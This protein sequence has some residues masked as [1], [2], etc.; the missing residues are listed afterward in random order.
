MCPPSVLAAPI[1]IA[2]IASDPFPGA[3]NS[4]PPPF[5]ATPWHPRVTLANDTVF[6]TS[7]DR[8]IPIRW[9]RIVEISFVFVVFHRAVLFV[10]VVRLLLGHGAQLQQQQGQ[11]GKQ[12]QRKTRDEPSKRAMTTMIEMTMTATTQAMAVVAT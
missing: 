10:V 11:Q 3:N 6:P 4:P 5:S 12:L 1:A 7:A 2:A 8:Y 9:D